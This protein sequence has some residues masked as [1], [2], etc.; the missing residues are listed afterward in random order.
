MSE[1]KGPPVE[2]NELQAILGLYE[3]SKAVFSTIKLYEL[4][5]L[6][7]QSI[8]KVLR[9]DE[10]SVMLLNEEKY[11]YIAS[12]LG[13]ERQEIRNVQLKIGERVAGLAVAQRKGFLLQEGLEKY[14]EFKGVEPNPRIFSSIVFPIVCRNELLGVLN[15]N[16]TEFREPF[17]EADLRQAAIFTSQA[18]QAIHNAKLYEQLERKVEEL[19]SA[20]KT[21]QETQT[22]LL[23]S[24]K[25]ASIGR[26]VAGVAHEINNPLTSVIGY[27]ELLLDYTVPQNI[28]EHLIVV[29]QEAHR[30]RKIVQDLLA[31]ARKRDLRGQTIHPCHVIDEALTVLELEFRKSEIKVIKQYVNPCPYVF[32][33]PSQLRQVFSNILMNAIHALKEIPS[34]RQIRINGSGDGDFFIVS[35]TDNGPG[36]SREH[37]DRVFDPFFTTKEVG[38]GTGLGLSLAY[39]IVRD[40]KGTIVVESDKDQGAAFT[41]RLPVFRDP[42]PGPHV[43]QDWV[44]GHLAPAARASVLVVEDEKALC[45]L[46]QAVLAD[47]GLSVEIAADGQAAYSKLK[48]HDYDLIICDQRMPKMSGTALY[49]KIQKEKPHLSRRF[50]FVTGSV[51]GGRMAAFCKENLLS[52][53]LKPFTRSDLLGAVDTLLSPSPPV[54]RRR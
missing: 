51:E 54:V 32:G 33:D 6:I 11:L 21:I 50:I 16:R 28:R 10:G 35:F 29:S 42:G 30:C 17:T 13:A 3:T 5:P 18:A 46:L 45:D 25:L 20:H 44:S 43:R 2:K 14:A 52:C 53:L 4:L 1:L 40:H 19:K 22:R 41:I 36:I 49:L 27:T 7:L 31:F 48:E 9:V 47:R 24:E 37:L 8:R 23:E 12:C 26:L 39:G 34:E 38:K 15:L